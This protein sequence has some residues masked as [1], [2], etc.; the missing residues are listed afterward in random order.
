MNFISIQINEIILNQRNIF[1][2]NNLFSEIILFLYL[3]FFILYIIF[4][5]LF[6]NEFLRNILSKLFN[7]LT[8]LDYP[9]L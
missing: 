6:G 1:L 8:S 4:D 3:I 5:P 2:R 9:F 7:N